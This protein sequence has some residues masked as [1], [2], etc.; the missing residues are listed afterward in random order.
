ML[1]FGA[2]SPDPQLYRRVISRI[3]EN[4]GVDKTDGIWDTVLRAVGHD[5]GL[6][7]STNVICIHKDRGDTR[8][9]CRSIAL[10]AP[11][12][13]P[14]GVE[15]T[16][17][18]TPGCQ[19][20]RQDLSFKYDPRRVRA[21]CRKCLWRSGWVSERDVLEYVGRLNSKLPG[22]YWCEYPPPIE[23]RRIFVTAKREGDGELMDIDAQ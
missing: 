12:V 16:L 8:V 4:I 21:T 18:G 9:S 3:I 14:W 15:F 5:A 7:R 6:L 22:V 11:A 17:C 20:S 2:A 23:L 19:H 10:H 1:G 13:R